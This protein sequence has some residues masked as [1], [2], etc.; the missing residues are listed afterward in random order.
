MKRIKLNRGFSAKVDD[1][2]FES[3]TK[4]K[5]RAQVNKN[6]VYAVRSVGRH[7][8]ALMHRDLLPGH[9]SIDHDDGDGLNNQRYN[10]KP[11]TATLNGQKFRHKPKGASSKFRGVSRHPQCEKWQVAIRVY[12][13]V[14]YLGIFADETEAARAYD[15]AAKKF[16]PEPARAL[17]FPV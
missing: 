8:K 2:D 15:A 10:L 12:G 13:K 5:W 1:E 14:K 11:S 16:F 6:H 4:F 17:N 3:L 7:S 9:P